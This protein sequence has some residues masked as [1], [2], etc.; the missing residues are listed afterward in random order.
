[1]VLV[2]IGAAITPL[3]GDD[4]TDIPISI[5]NGDKNKR[6][7]MPS[8]QRI[9]CYK[10]G[11]NLCIDFLHS[12]GDCELTI[13]TA[14]NGIEVYNFNSDLPT[15]INIGDV[16]LTYLEIETEIGNV[17]IGEINPE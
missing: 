14:E 4:V 15:M 7:K 16:T 5:T 12:E 6:P 13:I 10:D 9:Y 17:Y 8:A 2:V 1:M 3:Y 11:E